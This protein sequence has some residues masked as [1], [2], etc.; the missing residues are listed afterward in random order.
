MVV[1]PQKAHGVTGSLRKHLYE[2]M[3]SFFEETLK[4]N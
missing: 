4:K 2:T 3:L 1:Y